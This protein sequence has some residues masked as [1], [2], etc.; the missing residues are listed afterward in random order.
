ML[1]CNYATPGGNGHLFDVLDVGFR[2]M[3]GAVGLRQ[4][5]TELI[6][7][8]VKRG[9]LIKLKGNFPVTV[10]S[11]E[12]KTGAARMTDA[13]NYTPFQSFFRGLLGLDILEKR[14]DALEKRLDNIDC[15][16][17]KVDD[18]FDNVDDS[19]D[20]LLQVV[21]KKSDLKE[22]GAVFDATS[23]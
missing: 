2:G 23:N 11:Q 17:D 6:G 7:I 20:N 22:L 12:A 9:A 18:R 1:S 3:S 21:L 16:L 19:L 4:D 8:F 5:S 10:P 14:F 15:R 13:S